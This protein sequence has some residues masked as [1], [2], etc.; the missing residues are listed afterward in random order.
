MIVGLVIILVG[1]GVTLSFFKGRKT[2]GTKKVDPEQD[3]DRMILM[4]QKQALLR[5]ITQLD[6]D[7]H[8]GRI[9]TDQ[10]EKKRQELKDKAVEITIMLKG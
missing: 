6:E 9:A 7:H 1:T 5:S 8:S 3:S 2:R 4:E 10:Y